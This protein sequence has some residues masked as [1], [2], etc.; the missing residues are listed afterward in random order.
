MKVVKVAESGVILA[1]GLGG[2]FMCYEKQSL[3]D[4]AKRE[5]NKYKVKELSSGEVELWLVLD[6]DIEKRLNLLRL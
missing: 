5:P 2:E 1:D 3:L 4:V 6:K